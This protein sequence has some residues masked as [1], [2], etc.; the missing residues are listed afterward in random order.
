M[1]RRRFMGLTAAGAATAALAPT[2]TACGSGSGTDDV[3]LKLVAADYGD[4][5]SNSTLNYWGDLVRAFETKNRNIKVD[6][7][8]YSWT[9]IDKK[10]AEMIESGDTPDM[11]QFGTYADFVAQGMLYRADQI[12]S[13]R[14]MASFVSS[15]AQAGE[16]N[17]VQYA[18]PFGAST[19]LLFYNKA[20][21]ERA[22][23]TEPP[24]DW[25]E[26]QAAAEKLKAIDVK[27]PYALPLGREEA[28]AETLIWLLSGGGGYTDGYGSYM[29]DSP[30]NVET[31]EWLRDE[32]V[33]KGLTGS[34]PPGRL[35]RQEAFNAFT[36]GEV[37]MLNGHPTLMQQAVGHRIDYDVAP[38]P[39]RKGPSPTTMGVADW[40][41][42]FKKNGHRKQIGQFLNFVYETD[43]VVGFSGKYRLLPV[44][45]DASTVMRRDD[46]YKSLWQFLDG[47]DTAQFYPFDKV[48]W[49]KVNQSLRDSVGTMVASGGDPATVL[50]EIQRK[51]DAKEN[52]ER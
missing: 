24:K 21:F 34:R 52:E 47:L 15:I 5:S 11:V 46:E 32:F 4:S 17:R 10:V 30:E 26:L 1:Q 29:L 50:G 2:L 19:R 51:A 44:T 8:V 49:T 28:Q 39:G 6:V 13:I 14:T 45:T 12:L 42:A 18:M 25:D 40:M 22:G 23:I 7:N 16:V 48:S 27:Y 20:L 36:R 9:D 3:R 43:N 33:G 31:L 41:M 38:L 37:G 35:N